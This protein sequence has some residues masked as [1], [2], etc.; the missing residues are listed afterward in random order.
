MT[1]PQHVDQPE[2][3]RGGRSASWT[4]RNLKLTLRL[5]YAL[6]AAVFFAILIFWHVTFLARVIVAFVALRG[7]L[8]IPERL[9]EAEF[10]ERVRTGNFAGAADTPG[11]STGRKVQIL[12]GDI[13]DRT[14]PDI[15]VKAASYVAFSID[16]GQAEVIPL[17]RTFEDTWGIPPEPGGGGPLGTFDSLVERLLH[18]GL[19]FSTPV[20]PPPERAP[21]LM[22]AIS[23]RDLWRRGAW[24]EVRDH[25]PGERL[26]SLL[27]RLYAT[28]WQELLA[29]IWVSA[30]IIVTLLVSEN[31]LSQFSRGVLFYIMAVFLGVA[32]LWLAF[33]LRPWAFNASLMAGDEARCAYWVMESTEGKHFLVSALG[34][35]REK[36]RKRAVRLLLWN[37]AMLTAGVTLPEGMRAFTRRE[38]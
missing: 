21:A 38:G 12:R 32:A 33:V 1:L 2:P 24:R 3:E 15:A 27:F 7:L 30:A 23:W 4:R 18:N 11:I 10:V 8:I 25:H 26:L 31:W 9:S 28:E 36:L 6:S 17:A 35:G 34:S 19:R 13:S 20:S 37:D 16:Q 29:P 5:C 22:N 14:H